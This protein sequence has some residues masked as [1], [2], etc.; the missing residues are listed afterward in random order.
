MRFASGLILDV[1]YQA[2]D[3]SHLPESAQKLASWPDTS[4]TAARFGI[5]VC[6]LPSNS[7]GQPMYSILI[8]TY[9]SRWT[10]FLRI[11]WE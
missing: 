11:F 4:H 8:A 1:V 9:E 7:L 10:S 2:S 6:E 3:P 5:G